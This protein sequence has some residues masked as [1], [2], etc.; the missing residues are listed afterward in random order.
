MYRMFAQ[1]LMKVLLESTCIRYGT[2]RERQEKGATNA[3]L[4]VLCGL[5]AG[6]GDSIHTCSYHLGP[7]VATDIFSRRRSCSN[8]IKGKLQITKKN[9]QNRVPAH[10]ENNYLIIHS[11]HCIFHWL[12]Q[13]LVFCYLAQ[14]LTMTNCTLIFY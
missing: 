13:H 5:H 7:A 2:E 11:P 9:M 8:L 3:D 12:V 1:R 4:R 10:T 6:K 14:L